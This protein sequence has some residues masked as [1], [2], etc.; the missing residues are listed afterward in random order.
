MAYQTPDRPPLFEEGLR[1]DVLARWQSE[2]IESADRLREMV[3]YDLRERITLDLGPHPQLPTPVPCDS[4]AE[5]LRRSL[6]P[7]DPSRLPEDWTD[8][9][10]RWL[11]RDAVLEVWAHSGFFL[12]QAADVWD[13]VHRILLLSHDE[14]ERVRMVMEA[15]AACAVG[16]IKRMPKAIE[17]DMAIF[18]EPISGPDRPLLGPRM[19]RELALSTY[20]PIIEA[21]S[22]AGC[23]TIVF[24][25]YANSRALLKAVVEAGFNCLW[26]VEAGEGAMDYSEIRREFGR[27][28]RLIGGIDLDIL[29]TDP[30]T[31]R[32]A[33]ERIVAPLLN[34]GGYVPLADG[35]VRAD[36]PLANY[37]CYREE[38]ERLT[39]GSA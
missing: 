29:R 12:T 32:R 35:R 9:T 31:I 38:L 6:D 30:P 17:V 27:D 37:L 14:P 28:L 33:M 8:C 2:G 20:R 39:R 4:D 23:K 19:Y 15:V 36:V 3:S 22:E 7:M 5:T 1:D 10:D 25:T 16:L 18:S 26:S 24:Q 34:E 13:R 11:S 21:L